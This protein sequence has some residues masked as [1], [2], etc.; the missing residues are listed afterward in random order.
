[1]SK[2]EVSFK[3]NILTIKKDSIRVNKD[4]EENID[5][6]TLA[7][8]QVYFSEIK[9]STAKDRNTVFF[10]AEAERRKSA[11]GEIQAQ[12]DDTDNDDEEKIQNKN[13]VIVYSADGIIKYSYCNLEKALKKMVQ[14]KYKVFKFRLT[15][16]S[17]KINLLAYLVNKYSAKIG[18]IKFFIDGKIYKE[19]KLKQYQKQ[20]SKWNMLKDQNVYRFKFNLKDILD[21]S[22]TINGAIRFEVEV[23]GYNVDYKIGKVDKKIKSKKLPKKY[24]NLPIKTVNVGEYAVH[25]RRTISGNFVFVQRLLEPIEKTFKFRFLE[26]K[27]ISWTMYH[28]GKFGTKH[29]KK[30]INLFYEKFASKAEEGVYELYSKC[31]TSKKTKNY[32]I[33]DSN[34]NDYERIKNDKNVIKKYSFKYYWLIYNTSWFIASEAPSHLNILRSNNK[35]FRKATYDKKFVFLQHGIIYMKNLGVNSS[36]KKEKEGESQYMVVS[37]KKEM[38]VVTEMLDYGE[39]QL[40]N[41]GLGMYSNIDYKHI[42]Q[43]SEDVVTVMLTWKPYEEQLYNFEESSYYKNVVE[44]A[45]ML[46]KYI[47]KEK[48]ILIS[49][50]KA[51]SLLVNTNLKNTIWNKPISEALKKTKLLIT[52]YSSVCY[53]TF[54]QGGAVIFYQPDLKLYE[55]ENGPLIPDDEEY[56][57]KRAFNIEELENIIKETIKNEKINL[58]NVRT[59]KFEENYKTINEFSDGKNIDRIYEKLVELKLV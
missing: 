41:T 4:V 26:S 2:I 44:I 14:L 9:P 12:D 42:N 16:H 25:I 1:M 56:V 35:Y 3:D 19:C 33:I 40:L 31:K 53:N 34:S 46:E 10:F 32:F 15:K 11:R 21:D 50:P 6:N 22:S 30:K 18:N 28:L 51:Q 37:S 38:E 58:A 29:R 36:F 39:E 20:I 52:D 23:N 48:I 49:H 54:Y 13:A 59:A 55:E 7:Y 45:R 47:N 43:D 24:Y 17:V 57:G 5:I 8:D 27:F